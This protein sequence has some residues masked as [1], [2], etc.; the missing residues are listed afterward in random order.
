MPAFEQC[1]S[2]NRTHGPP[3]AFG[4]CNPPQQASDELTIGTADSNG[5]PNKSEGSV[6]VTAIAGAPATPADEANVLLTLAI[7]DVRRRDNLA[8]YTGAV[9]PRLPLRVTDRNNTPG[10]APTRASPPTRWARSCA[11]RWT[12]S[13]RTR[14]WTRWWAFPAAGAPA[15]AS[16]SST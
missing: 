1:T 8:D 7:T 4:S 15:A 2:L 11:K 12:S 16:C 3:L 10:C 13:T 9:H 14:Q 5:Q 6:L